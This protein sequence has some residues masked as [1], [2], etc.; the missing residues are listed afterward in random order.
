MKRT[1]LIAVK[2]I[3]CLVILLSVTLPHLSGTWTGKLTTADS[4]TYPLTY[5]FTIHGDSVAGTVKSTLGEFPIE[6]GKMD[7]GGLH[8]KVTMNGL[9]IPHNGIVYADSI[10]MNIILNGSRVHCRLSRSAN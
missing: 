8:F 1:G 3:A 5:N 9:D 10:G 4:M 6:E 2:A 7:T